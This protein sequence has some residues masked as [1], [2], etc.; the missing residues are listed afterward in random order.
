MQPEVVTGCGHQIENDKREES[1][2]LE[3]K[4]GKAPVSRIADK[5]AYQRIDIA[6]TVE[7]HDGEHAMR[8]AEQEHGHTQVAAIVEQRQKAPVEPAEGADAENH[9]QQEQ[10]RGSESA[11]Q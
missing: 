4:I 9:V 1:E 5:H 3:R 7:L 2:R 10:R 8:E 11:N 6:E